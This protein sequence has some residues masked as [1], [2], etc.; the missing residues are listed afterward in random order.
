MIELA[1]RR[2][3]MGGQGSGLP[4]DAE[5]KYIQSS[6][7][8]YINTRLTPSANL[9][10]QFG[11]VNLASTGDVIVGTSPNDNADYRFFNASGQCYY[12]VPNSKR[13][14]GSSCSPSIY[15]EFELGNYY[16]K[17][18]VSGLKIIQGSAGIT[19]NNYQI[20]ICG[21]TYNHRSKNRI[22]WFKGYVSNEIKIDLI[23]VRKDGIGYMYD[24]VSGQL[25][26]NQ[27]TGN[28]ILGPD[29]TT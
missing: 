8:Q 26:A 21:D 2:M 13:I 19:S 4:Y 24:K 14:N 22:Y 11:F 15:Y 6:G 7:T 10:L 27:G 23:P 9:V 3:M 20:C 16:V 12:D 1:R 29:K 17:D 28:F 18:L 5:L 25:F